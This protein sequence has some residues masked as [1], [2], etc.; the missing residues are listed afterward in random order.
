[1]MLRHLRNWIDNQSARL[2]LLSPLRGGVFDFF[3]GALVPLAMP[4]IGAWP[5]LFFVFPAL[6]IRLQRIRRWQNIASTAWLFGFGQFLIGLYWI[7]FAFLVEPDLF[8]WALPFAV[9]LLPASLAL[10][11][12]FAGLLWLRLFADQPRLAIRALGLVLCLVLASWVRSNILTGL[13]WNLYGMSALSWLPLAQSARLWGVHG[14]SLLM[15]CFAMLP[16]FFRH[17]KKLAVLLSIGFLLLIW[18]GEARLRSFDLDKADSPD[19]LRV[20][21]VQPAI[22]QK[23]KWVPEN[24]LGIIRTHLELTGQPA[25]EAID[26]VVWPETA[27]P[28]L[29][30]RDVWLREQISDILPDGAYLVTGGLRRESRAETSP[31]ATTPDGDTLNKQRPWQSFNSIFVISPTGDI[32]DFYD[33]HHLVPFGEYLP[34]QQVLEMLGLQQLTRLRGGFTAGDGPKSLALNGLGK[35][36]SPLICYEVIFPGRVV[37]ATRP[38]FLITVT[39]DGWFGKSAGPWQHLAMARM[40]SIEEGLPLIRSANTGVSGVFDALG[41]QIAI[42][43]LMQRGVLDVTLPLS[44]PSSVPSTVPVTV[45]APLYARYGDMMFFLIFLVVTGL[46]YFQRHSKT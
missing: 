29:L 42:M 15:L 38:D 4:P 19:A 43:P 30:R 21:I 12:M 39:N 26:L 11:P 6:L 18:D 24:R 33:K 13:P 37:G 17:E 7:G 23:E 9:T 36:F 44:V 8:L 40:R 14:L 25:D 32:E 46:L 16:L 27:L 5:L 31:S 2:A 3:L 35:T 45:D 22:Q 41:R 1:M 10:F 34:Q 28:A 20:R